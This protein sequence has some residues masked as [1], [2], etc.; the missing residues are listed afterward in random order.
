MIN[1]ENLEIKY[2]DFVAMNKLNIEIKEGE[3]FTLLGPSGCGKTSLLR[4]ITGFVSPS[5]GK[6]VIDGDDVTKK[7]VENR[8]IGIV[9]QSYAIFPTMNVYENIAFGLK[10]KKLSAEEIKKQV[11]EIAKM[12]D[13]DED[14]L[15][16]SP[17]DLSG[18]QQ[19]RVAIARALV[20]KPKIL[21]LDEPLSNLDAKLRQQLRVEIKELQKKFGITTIYV[22]HDQEEALVI[23][24]RIAVFDKGQLQQVGTPKEIFNQPK[25]DFVAT[26]IDEINSFNTSTLAADLKLD[27]QAGDKNKTYIRLNNV[28]RN[29][30]ENDVELDVTIKNVSFQG[31]FVKYLLVDGFG[32]E[33]KMIDTDINHL[34]E[35][36][37]SMQVYINQKDFINL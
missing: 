20:L 24:D 13:L 22:T 25:N 19:Q 17:A 18:G 8:G 26:F 16:K 1:L 3:F 15:Y 34:F 30:K 2:G 29:K 31:N 7:S 12:V 32:H 11:L 5:E 10:V 14:Q 37:D 27:I 28:R 4:A 33:F 21:C 9:F 23:S 6:I 36:N 35:E